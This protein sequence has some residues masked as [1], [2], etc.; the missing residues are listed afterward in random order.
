MDENAAVYKYGLHAFDKT[1][2]YQYTLRRA[3]RPV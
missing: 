3:L 1:L 2:Q